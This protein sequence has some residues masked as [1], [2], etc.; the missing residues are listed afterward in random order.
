MK[1]GDP[2]PLNNLFRG[3]LARMGVQRDRLGDSTGVYED[4]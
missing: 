1:L 4:F 2:L 3:M